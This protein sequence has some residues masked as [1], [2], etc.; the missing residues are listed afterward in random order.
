MRPYHIRQL[1]VVASISATITVLV[2]KVSGYLLLPTTVVSSSNE[3][4]FTSISATK[5][6][7]SSLLSDQPDTTLTCLNGFALLQTKQSP[8]QTLILADK[9]GLAI[10]CQP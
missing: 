3:L 8:Q 6:S 1:I 10:K 4:K 5:D 7:T 9:N 2:L